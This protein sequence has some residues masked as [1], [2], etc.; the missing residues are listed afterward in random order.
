M[1]PLGQQQALA[2]REFVEKVE[3]IKTTAEFFGL[4]ESEYESINKRAVREIVKNE[5]FGMEVIPEPLYGTIADSVTSYLSLGAEVSH[6]N[7]YCIASAIL[8][9]TGLKVSDYSYINLSKD[10]GILSQVLEFLYDFATKLL[11]Q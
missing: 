11:K 6:G 7:F 5:S 1:L 2:L 8:P 9:E 3:N 4:S 10:S